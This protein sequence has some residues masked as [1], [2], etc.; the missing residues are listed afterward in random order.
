MLRFGQHENLFLINMNIQRWFGLE[1]GIICTILQKQTSTST[2]PYAALAGG[3]FPDGVGATTLVGI[4]SV[5][6]ASSLLTSILVAT[7]VPPQAIAHRA[8]AA[9][10]LVLWAVPLHLSSQSEPHT[11][12]V[13]T[14][15]VGLRS[16]SRV[17]GRITEPRGN[18]QCVELR[19]SGYGK[20]Y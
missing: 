2:S 4:I 11:R 9:A 3:G 6:D 15:A 8:R 5:S 18:V 13:T 14:F 1:C 7:L 10:T 16:Y 20:A 19:T 12:S 17:L